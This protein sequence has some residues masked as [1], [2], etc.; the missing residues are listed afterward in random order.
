MNS[1]ET[2]INYLAETEPLPE[3]LHYRLTK[4]RLHE[5]Q[6]GRKAAWQGGSDSDHP[7]EEKDT[8]HQEGRG[9]HPNE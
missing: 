3:W 2:Y 8:G 1:K 6:N 5:K 7:N 9:E 4:Q